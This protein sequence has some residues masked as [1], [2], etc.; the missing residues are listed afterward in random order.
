MSTIPTASPEEL[1]IFLK[2]AEERFAELGI[3]PARAAQL[4]DTQLN[5]LAG[6]VFGKDVEVAPTKQA[7]QV[8]PDEVVYKA[9][10]DRMFELGVPK[11]DADACLASFAE[12]TAQAARLREGATHLSAHNS[13]PSEK[14]ANFVK[15]ATAVLAKK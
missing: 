2:S 5:K 4:F 14:V 8:D 6:E 9:A 15:K 12:R 3:D 10:M 13:Q 7:E 11:A 1:E